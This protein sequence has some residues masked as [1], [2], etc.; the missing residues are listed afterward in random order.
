[1]IPTWELYQRVTQDHLH[2]VIHSNIALQLDIT[3]SGIN[4]TMFTFRLLLEIPIAK[5]FSVLC[6]HIVKKETAL[7][8]HL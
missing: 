3:E 1:M 4:Y 8:T 6:P 2:R 5:L 7:F